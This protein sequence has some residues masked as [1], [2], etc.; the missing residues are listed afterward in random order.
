MSDDVDAKEYDWNE[1]SPSKLKN[2][3][4]AEL[5]SK[6][7]AVIDELIGEGANTV[8][9]IESINFVHDVSSSVKI[10]ISFSKKIETSFDSF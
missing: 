3:S 10:N 7:S 1:G 4:I 9:N 5:E 6:L 2:V 8:G